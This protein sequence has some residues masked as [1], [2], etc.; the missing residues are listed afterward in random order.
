MADRALSRLVEQYG[1]V[2]DLPRGRRETALLRTA[3]QELWHLINMGDRRA[4]LFVAFQ[5]NRAQHPVRQLV[6]LVV[7][8]LDQ[9]RRPREVRDTPSPAGSS[10]ET[11]QGYGQ[12]PLGP[13][14][15]AS[16]RLVDFLPAQAGEAILIRDEVEAEA[17]VSEPP[18]AEAPMA[19]PAGATEKIPVGDAG[20]AA[21][22]DEPLSPIAAFARDNPA[23]AEWFMERFD[24]RMPRQ[25]SQPVPTG[26]STEKSP[27]RGPVEG[28]PRRTRAP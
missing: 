6:K 16:R 11:M 13:A 7:D 24:K 21:S 25:A 19:E 5:A 26:P 3:W 23:T 17:T 4:L 10:A 15:Y 20:L 22:A 12:H 28:Q 1:A 8:S 2:C 9:A 27:P 18:T 14:H